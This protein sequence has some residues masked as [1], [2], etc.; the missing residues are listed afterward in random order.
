MEHLQ[1]H[2]QRRAVLPAAGRNKVYPPGRGQLLGAGRRA[3][4]SGPVPQ[5]PLHPGARRGGG[6][7]LRID[8][9]TG[10][11]YLPTYI[12]TTEHF[13]AW[14][15]GFPFERHWVWLLGFYLSSALFNLVLFAFL[16]DRIHLW[17][18]AYVVGVTC[19]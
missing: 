19:F 1:L 11:I 4:L 18:V 10:G 7:L 8:L 9:H 12:E 15:M 6:A 13:L 5:L 14:E 3:G 17:Y 16:R 2:R